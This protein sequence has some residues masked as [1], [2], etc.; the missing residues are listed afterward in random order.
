MALI[1]WIGLQGEW[2]PVLKRRAL[3]AAFVA[4]PVALLVGCRIVGG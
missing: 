4:G 3:I 1:H 2:T